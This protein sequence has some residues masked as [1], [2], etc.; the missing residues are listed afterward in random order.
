MAI[1]NTEKN[2]IAEI[3]ADLRNGL[4]WDF[5]PKTGQRSTNPA[6]SCVKASTARDK[7]RAATW[8]DKI[9]EIYKEKGATVWVNEDD[10]TL[11]YSIDITNMPITLK[12]DDVEVH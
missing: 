9:T 2:M 5:D 6:S 8:L 10:N 12:P 1:D 4:G 7:K 11:S 3:E